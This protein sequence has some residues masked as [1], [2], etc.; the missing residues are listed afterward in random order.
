MFTH[1]VVSVIH[2]G[3]L[4]LQ[5]AYYDVGR[6]CEK[7]ELDSEVATPCPPKP[8][9]LSLSDSSSAAVLCLL[10]AELLLVVYQSPSLPDILKLPNPSP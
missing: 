10:L 1:R 5:L 3:R 2:H 4:H 8:P 9:F 7:D 6:T